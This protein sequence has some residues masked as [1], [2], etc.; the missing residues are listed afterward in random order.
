MKSKVNKQT[1]RKPKTK[2]S[3]TK[4]KKQ[5]T[6]KPK[7]KQSKSKTK[8]KQP[9]IRLDIEK[10][11]SPK[12]IMM[13]T[14]NTKTGQESILEAEKMEKNGLNTVMVKAESVLPPTVVTRVGPNHTSTSMM[15]MSQKRQMVVQSFHS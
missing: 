6:R 3:K 12:K 5:V 2:Q 10:I 7:T 1:P 11:N 9:N 4:T 15:S 8:S 14:K 13:F